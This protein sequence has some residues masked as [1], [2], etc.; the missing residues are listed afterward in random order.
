[1]NTSNYVCLD[2]ETT[3]LEPEICDVIEIAMIKV[4]DG[5][6]VD[7]FESFVYTPLEISQHVSYLTGISAKDLEGAPDFIDL[8]DKV[9]EFIGDDPMVGHNIWF[10]WNFLMAKGIPLENTQLWDT[11]T[12][13]TILY[14]ELPSHSL[15]TNTKYF[16][17]SHEDSHRAMAD[18][19]ASHELWLILTQTFPEISPEQRQQIQKLKDTSSWPLLDYFLQEKPAQKTAIDLPS[20]ELYHP[21]ELEAIPVNDQHLFVEGRG[22]DIVDLAA[23]VQK[24]G[25]ILYVGAFSHT[26]HK[27][28]Q[29]FPE[30]FHLEAPFL[31]LSEQRLQN[32]WKKD[33]HED[34]EATLLLKTVLYPDKLCQH[35]LAL[36]HPERKHWSQV[37]TTEDEKTLPENAYQQALQKALAS[38]KV[39]MSQK[40]LLNHLDLLQH[41]DHLVLLEPQLLEDNATWKFGKVMFPDQ[42]KDLSPEADWQKKGEQLFSM[43]EQIARSIVPSSQ[44]PEHIS[45][46]DIVTQ[47]NEFI[48]AKSLITELAA[49]TK[50]ESLSIY[51]KYFQAFFQQDPSWIRWM[52]IDPRRGLSI[53]I[54]PL[55]VSSMLGKHLFDTVPSTIISNSSDHF[56]GLP[57]MDHLDRSQ[58]VSLE[59]T[60][61]DPIDISGT[62]KSGDHQALISYLA[63]MIPKQSGK[64]GVV[65]SSKTAMKRY[66]FDIAK[67][68]PE[69]TAIFAED[70]SGGAGKLRDRYHTSEKSHKVLFIS[71][72][73]LRLFAP[74]LLDFDQIF[75]QNLPFDPPGYP[76]HQVRSA[77]VKNG[78]MD[79]TLPRTKQNILEML[80][81][82]TQRDSEKR[83]FL[84]DRRIQE[85]GYGQDILDLL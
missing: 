77:Q 66:F 17:I 34:A 29:V 82:F 8:K 12:M 81:A 65:F 18:V 58:K 38:D 26:L 52:T 51:L 20:T 61:P 4:R 3:G 44:Y 33:Q 24:P 7:R 64:T 70:L 6:I 72:R 56:P 32:L 55:S 1:M 53:S 9:T 75:M 42:W 36:S 10:D 85:K 48:R 30:A 25:K 50:E 13:S 21:K 47:S 45:L 40:F 49:E 27:L 31:Y 39:I 80:A 78:F 11:Y 68:M 5:E 63:A 43:L 37:E 22:Q 54:M 76:I 2:L 79:Y 71:F 62:K 57:E 73:S 60:L 23:A 59:L 19:I 84:L 74:E 35:Q 41:F 15:E 14:P 69:D 83:L 67:T 28:D 46:T 16:G